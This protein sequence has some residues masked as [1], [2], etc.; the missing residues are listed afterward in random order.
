VFGVGFLAVGYPHVPDMIRQ[1]DAG[2]I[3]GILNG[4]A[5]CVG[6]STIF[7]TL[8]SRVGIDSYLVIGM[9]HYRRHTWNVVI[10]NDT[11]FYFDLTYDIDH[12]YLRPLMTRGQFYTVFNN[13]R[14][15]DDLFEYLWV[16]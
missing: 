10:L 4:E 12:G 1:L 5:V 2:S 6:F 11:L 15:F 16:R 3:V 7:N 13:H 14:P 9:V 8:A